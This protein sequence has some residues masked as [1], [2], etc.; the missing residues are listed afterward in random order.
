[1]LPVLA[2]SG[3]LDVREREGGGWR[4]HRPRGLHH[5]QVLYPIRKCFYLHWVTKVPSCAAVQPETCALWAFLIL[6]TF[7]NVACLFPASQ[8]C[9]QDPQTCHPAPLHQLAWL[10]SSLLAH[11]HVEV[12]QKGQGHQPRFLWACRGPLQVLNGLVVS[13][14]VLPVR[15]H[16]SETFAL[17]CVPT[18]TDVPLFGCCW[19][20]T[21]SRQLSVARPLFDC[22]VCPR[23][24]GVGR[25]GTFIVIDAMIEMMHAEQNVDVF[26]FV[27][28]I[29]SQ[30]SQLVQTDVSVAPP[31]GSQLFRLDVKLIPVFWPQMQYSFIYQALLEYFLYGDTEL[32][33]SSLEGHLH[34]LHNTFVDGDRVGLEEEFKVP[35][36]DCTYSPS[37]NLFKLFVCWLLPRNWPTCV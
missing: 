31:H 23:S 36:K 34:K 1:M 16:L 2:W 11:R 10:W 37:L 29:R 30:R 26:G 27:S 25:T 32:D 7:V 5:T 14:H 3:L 8:R 15:V 18:R 17:S 4:L 19:L 6:S 35:G 20:R 12:P 13:R 28:K 22:V 33:V 24:A 9:R 21:R